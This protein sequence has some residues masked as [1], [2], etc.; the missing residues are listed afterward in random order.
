MRGRPVIAIQFNLIQFM[1]DNSLCQLC[2]ICIIK[3]LGRHANLANFYVVNIT[4]EKLEVSFYLTN[5]SCHIQK[6]LVRMTHHKK[7]GKY[8]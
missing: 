8:V 4:H 7:S 6:L 5:K 1:C 2:E 3:C